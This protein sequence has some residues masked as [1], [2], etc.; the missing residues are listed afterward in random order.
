MYGEVCPTSKGFGGVE[1]GGVTPAM[2]GYQTCQPIF[3]QMR[4]MVTINA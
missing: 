3:A 1:Y 4:D 2:L